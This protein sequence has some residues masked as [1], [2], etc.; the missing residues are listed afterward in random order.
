MKSYDP[1]NSST[2]GLLSGN[3]T[4]GS[5]LYPGVGFNGPCG[6]W[7]PGSISISSITSQKGAYFICSF[8][9]SLSSDLNTARYY[10][11]HK[12]LKWISTDSK[13]FRNIPG[14]IPMITNEYNWTFYTIRTN[15]R[16]NRTVFQTIGFFS[17]FELTTYY[18]KGDR[19]MMTEKFLKFDILACADNTTIK[20]TVRSGVKNKVKASAF[21]SI[22]TTQTVRALSTFTT[23]PRIGSTTKIQSGISTESSITTTNK[24]FLNTTTRTLPFSLQ[25]YKTPTPRT[26]TVRTTTVLTTRKPIYSRVCGRF[27]KYDPTNTENLRL[28]RPDIYGFAGGIEYNGAPQY[29]AYGDNR[30][31]EFFPKQNPCSGYVLHNSQ[32]P[33]VRMSCRTSGM[34]YDNLNG[35]YL[36]NH[37]NLKWVTINNM[38][39]L[40]DDA[41]TIEGQGWKFL[42]GRFLFKRDYR[43]GKV[44]VETVR[45]IPRGFY[46]TDDNFNTKYF[47]SGFQILTCSSCENGGSGRFCCLN[48]ENLN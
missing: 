2:P 31:C 21:P 46:M 13:N 24:P 17:L 11:A 34:T 5:S 38:D 25:R 22:F 6:G 19:T 27:T 10:Y 12:N 29:I 9:Y 41:L 33:A 44:Q 47:A 23:T 20:A 26:T 42:F 36:L 43:I 3:F 14:I 48:G 4:D 16:Y 39:E 1:R 35:S 32:Y 30:D 8:V 18:W 40:T 7:I 37:P 45:D 28:S 15:V